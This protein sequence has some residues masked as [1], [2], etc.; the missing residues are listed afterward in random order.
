MSKRFFNKGLSG[1]FCAPVAAARAVAGRALKQAPPALLFAVSAFAFAAGG[2]TAAPASAAPAGP[3][4]PKPTFLEQFFPFIL[5]GL[6]F[7]FLIIRPQKAKARRH[8]GF[9]GGLKK[10]DE[11]VT[12]FGLFGKIEG[13]SDRFVILEVASG[14]RV[15]VLKT[16]IASTM[17]EEASLIKEQNAE[18][19]RK[20]E[21][22]RKSERK[23][24]A[25][26]RSRRKI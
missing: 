12:S 1:R 14:V 4:S 21:S 19:E 2:E 23:R 13:L 18:K 8:E 22:Q 16:K 15:R 24:A 17:K 20:S 11:V 5:I 3:A 9:L 26:A 25:L 7:Y 6:V 10:G